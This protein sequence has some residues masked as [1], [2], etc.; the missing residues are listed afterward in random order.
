MRILVG[1]LLVYTCKNNCFLVESARF[2]SL[3]VLLVTAV[4]SN[5][6]CAAPDEKDAAH[7]MG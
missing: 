3:F 2:Q 1:L 4:S 5:M 7:A 6:A